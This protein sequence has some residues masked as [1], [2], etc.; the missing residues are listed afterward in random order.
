MRARNVSTNS[1]TTVPTPVLTARRKGP[2]PA[3]PVRLQHRHCCYCLP[4]CFVLVGSVAAAAAA[5]AAAEAGSHRSTGLG[6]WTE[7]TPVER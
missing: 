1:S 3:T 2:L 7:N 5:A 6:P 4:H